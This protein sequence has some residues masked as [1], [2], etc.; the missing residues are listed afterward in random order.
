M[1]N[2]LIVD[3]EQ[4]ILEWLEELFRYEMEEE[5]DVYTVS[6]AFGALELLNQI[7]FDVVLSDIKMPGMDGIKLH[8][9]I[10][11]NWP[12]CRV[13]F[14]SAYRNF[15]YMYQLCSEHADIQYVLKSESDEKIVAAVKKA[16]QNLEESLRRR[17]EEE[18][19][20]LLLE[21]A[22]ERMQKDVL[23]ML[24]YP[25]DGRRVTEEQLREAGMDFNL[26]NPTL[27]CLLRLNRGENAENWDGEQLFVSAF[28]LL[29]KFAPEGISFYNYILNDTAAVVLVQPYQMEQV[30]WKR[31]FTVVHGALEYTQESF[32]ETTGKS[33]S[34]VISSA[35]I[36]A[37]QLG[38]KIFQLRKI[39]AGNL[40]NRESV[41]VHAESLNL[42]EEKGEYF[43][44]NTAIDQLSQ[45]LKILKRA[46]YFRQLDVCC[47]KL[48][49]YS[50]MH[51]LEALALYYGIAAVLLS[52]ITENHL[53]QKLPFQIGLYKLLEIRE[54]N[55]WYD[56]GQYLMELSE[57]IFAVLGVKGDDGL[58]NRTMEY[59]FDYIDSHLDQDLTL[60][61]L[62]ELSG[63][64]ASY[65]SR[66]FRQVK[67]ITISEYILERRMEL[68][69][70]YLGKTNEKIK[71]IAQKTGYLSAH[72]FTRAFRH[73]EGISPQEY[74]ERTI[75][76]RGKDRD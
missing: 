43:D 27:V 46:E 26:F 72:S 15:D 39:M 69:K 50:S 65:L 55:T 28:A 56:A 24:I 51:D 33:F 31:I 16:F 64:N 3:D 49:E 76:L 11:K 2:L 74:R 73:V 5:T 4:E 68:A 75:N 71:D 41:I 23:R 42:P 66:L 8:R 30:I 19:E 45:N 32:L 12:N 35:K 13:V 54:H 29:R 44:A 17:M 52:F 38:E 57:K 22:R 20:K 53:N 48:A 58:M 40:D 25:V 60:T 10:K 63:F 67:N 1:G 47:A 70:G 61:R 14:L 59:L 34:A 21:K 9:E 18:E 7:K 62:A 6:S 36:S 37:E